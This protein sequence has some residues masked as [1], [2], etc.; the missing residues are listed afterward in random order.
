MH[1]YH[2]SWL[3]TP[4][5]HIMPVAVALDLIMLWKPRPR[6]PGWVCA[7]LVSAYLASGIY[8]TRSILIGRQIYD[9]VPTTYFEYSR[10]RLVS[11]V[12]PL[13]PDSVIA[14]DVNFVELAASAERQRS[15]AGRDLKHNMV[16]GNQ[17]R[18]I[19]FALDQYL[20]GMNHDS[21]VVLLEGYRDVPEE[22]RPAYLHTFDEVSH[23]SE[24]FIDR[25]KVRYLVLPAAQR[26]PPFLSRGW[27]LVQPGPYW[28]IWERTENSVK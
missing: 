3:V 5:I 19:R 14:G 28:Q 23:D 9:F 1:D 7:L 20:S 18:Q 25:F 16:I 15:L 24:R 26:P 12:K 11:G 8:L 22:Q 6:M 13:R 27:N 17:E 21:L 2:W 4:L 10:Q